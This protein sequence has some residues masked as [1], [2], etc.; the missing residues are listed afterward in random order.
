MYQ[1]LLANAFRY[2]KYGTIFD[3]LRKGYNE[4]NVKD[5]LEKGV[6]RDALLND[7]VAYPALFDPRDYSTLRRI[8]P[9][10]E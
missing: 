6:R 2:S 4:R 7:F 9:A 1:K 3:A 5:Y 10:Y 8:N